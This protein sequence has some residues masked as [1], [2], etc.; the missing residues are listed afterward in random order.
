MCVDDVKYGRVEEKE[1]IRRCICDREHT[2]SK[3]STGVVCS[4][5]NSADNVAEI[6]NNNI[7]YRTTQKMSIIK[8]FDKIK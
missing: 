4:T 3:F 7:V 2:I 8:E 5:S 6:R 1:T